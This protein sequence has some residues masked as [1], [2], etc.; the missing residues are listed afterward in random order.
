MN[1]DLQTSR[2]VPAKQVQAFT[3][4]ELLT[5][6]SIIGIIAG[7]LVG[8]AP[9]ASRRMKES[10]VRAEMQ[11]IILLID[12]YKA[13]YGVYPPDGLKYVGNTEIGSDAINPL[14]YELSGVVAYVPMFM[15]KGDAAGYY[16]SPNR[17]EILTSADAQALFNKDGIINSVPADINNGAVS[18][19][20]DAS[21]TARAKLLRHTFKPSQYSNYTTNGHTATI[22]LAGVPWPANDSNQPL[23][24]NPGLNPWHY[25]SSR[26]LQNPNSY[27]LWASIKAGKQIV[28][29]GNWKNSQ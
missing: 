18:P 15:G 17:N 8:L 20:F 19:P 27:D 3:L 26:P 13:K 11:E 6:I 28:T 23:P 9:L 1:V 24:G 21:P 25:V 29:I 22:L 7:L 16:I 2:R 10:K 12:S 4:I 14:F 5:V